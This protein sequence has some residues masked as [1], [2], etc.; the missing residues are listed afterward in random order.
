VSIQAP[1]PNDPPSALSWSIVGR[2][3]VNIVTLL[4]A[5]FCSLLVNSVS[6]E[7]AANSEA[8][9]AANE[10]LARQLAEVRQGLSER[11]NKL[12]NALSSG[13]DKNSSS[14]SELQLKAG[15][16]ELRVQQ[17]ERFRD[18]LTDPPQV[19]KPRT[20]AAPPEALPADQQWVLFDPAPLVA[21]HG[22]PQP[23]VLGVSNPTP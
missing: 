15:L 13:S 8:S 14:V 12:E 22:H 23:M 19:K 11:I 6:K 10:S 2:W 1:T 18:A 20:R 9:K 4:I 17:L 16:L 21:R 3:A 5:A 7:I